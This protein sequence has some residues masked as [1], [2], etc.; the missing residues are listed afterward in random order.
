MIPYE[1][2][3][4]YLGRR[5]ALGWARGEL[6]LSISSALSENVSVNYDV[7]SFKIEIEKTSYLGSLHLY[8]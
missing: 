7:P 1:K 3:R 4:P 6:I 2:G 5:C 8:L